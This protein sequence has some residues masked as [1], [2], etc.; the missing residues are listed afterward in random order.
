MLEDICERSQTHPN[1][2]RREARYKIRD[3][4]RK[5]QLEWK[6]ALKDTQD[7]GKGLHK[8]FKHLVKKIL[9]E[10]TPLQESGSEVSHYIPELRNFVEVTKI[11]DNMKKPWL[12]ESLKEI[13]NLINNQNF[14]I[15]YPNKGEPVT[16]CMDV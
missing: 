14:L 11:K 16:P 2:N 6:G 10:L 8:V 15:E 4:I 7:M 3:I 9:Q 1:T 12:K 13:N 5:R